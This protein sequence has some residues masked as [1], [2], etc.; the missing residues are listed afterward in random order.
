MNNQS[1]KCNVES[2]KYNEGACACTLPSI[3]VGNDFT[4]SLGEAQ[5]KEETECNSFEP[6]E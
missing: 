5:S 6:Y 2:C 1:I 3:D 4:S